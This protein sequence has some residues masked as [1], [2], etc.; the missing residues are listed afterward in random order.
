MALF[1]AARRALTALRGWS[2]GS[3]PRRGL[4]VSGLAALAVVLALVWWP[5]GAWRPYDKDDTGTIQE[6]AY[7]VVP[8]G[9][10]T[11]LFHNL[12][13]GAGDGSGTGEAPAGGP[14]APPGSS[15][16]TGTGTGGVL[17]TGVPGGL[18]TGQ[19][20]GVGDL[21]KPA[22]TVERG[23]DPP[24]PGGVPVPGAT[25]SGQ[26][27]A[28]TSTSSPQPSATASVDPTP[29]VSPTP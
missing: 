25:A 4:V 12:F 14:Q 11:P 16:G 26:A 5:D 1:G 8:V 6:T 15:T 13:D 23:V 28:P 2:E 27:S 21:P 17:P 20:P 7:Q 29:P 3:G 9:K 18:P 22:A 24:D 10:G 19:L